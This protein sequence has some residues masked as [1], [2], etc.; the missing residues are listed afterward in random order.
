[1]NNP[2][3][4]IL[5]TFSIIC[6]LMA[7]VLLSVYFMFQNV[8]KTFGP[9]DDFISDQQRILLSFRL[10]FE[11]E[12]LF[13]ERTLTTEVG[14]FNIGYGESVAS[15]ADRLAQLGF[16]GNEQA[17]LHYMQYKGLDKSVQAGE[18]K[19]P[20]TLSDVQLANFLQDATPTDAIINVLAGWRIE[21]IAASLPNTGVEF[22]ALEFA[23]LAK[24][25][26]DYQIPFGI[27]ANSL[28]GFLL[29]GRYRIARDS[30]AN[31]LIVLLTAEFEKALS[32]DI[33][34]QIEQ[35]GISL[36]EG[37]ILASMI[38]REAINDEEMPMIASVFYNRIEQGMKFESDP[39]IQY[40]IGKTDAGNWWKNPLSAADLQF[41]S[42][43]NTYLEEGL[44]PTPICNPSLAALKAAANP[45]ESPYYYF[46]AKCDGS[47]WHNFSETFDQHVQNLCN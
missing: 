37:M 15:V 32:G 18:Y 13:E 29:P 5:L 4:K 11:K 16:I 36:Y 8:E 40:A 31:D 47:G 19:I 46:M 27:E 35:N 14:V 3:A 34:K 26:Q 41:V 1:M 2:L 25:P 9:A 33:K 17:F 45:A 7:G 38:E 12:S 10:F 6:L 21:E 43:Y 42:L 28:E 44:P 22:E 20:Q 24:N 39:T 23:L 30:S